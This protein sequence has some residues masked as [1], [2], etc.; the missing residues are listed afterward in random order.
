MV[1]L[2]RLDTHGRR[3][4]A[5]LR[6]FSDCGS[7]TKSSGV[8]CNITDVSCF[9]RDNA[10]DGW[11]FIHSSYSCLVDAFSELIIVPHLVINFVNDRSVLLRVVV[12]PPN[13][14]VRESE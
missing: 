12:H 10:E 2:I 6:V 7:F 8:F 9:E 1:L 14:S 4:T 3:R 5:V 11:V 13:N